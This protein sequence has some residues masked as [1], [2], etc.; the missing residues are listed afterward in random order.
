MNFFA[1][2]AIGND[3][4]AIAGTSLP[5]GAQISGWSLQTGTTIV[6]SDARLELP[7]LAFM[8]KKELC[9]ALPIRSKG[10]V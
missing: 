8:T 5:L 2:D 3:N 10:E 4:D 6:N 1:V 7:D 9:I